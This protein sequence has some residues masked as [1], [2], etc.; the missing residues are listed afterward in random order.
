MRALTQQTRLYYKTDRVEQSRTVHTECVQNTAVPQLFTAAK[1]NFRS[2]DLVRSGKE[3]FVLP[4][5][6]NVTF[7]FYIS[8]MECF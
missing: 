8:S 1:A 3:V 4:L 6:R 2:P 5:T 7:G